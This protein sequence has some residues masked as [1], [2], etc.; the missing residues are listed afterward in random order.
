MPKRFG[1][2]EKRAIAI[3]ANGGNPANSNDTEVAR[4]WQWKINPSNANHKLPTTSVRANNRKLSNRNITPFN[5]EMVAGTFA[6][7][8]ISARTATAAQ[9]IA[10]QLGYQTLTA[11]QNS[12]P[13]KKFKPAQVYWRTGAA[14]TSA[15]RT[16]RITGRSYKSYYTNADEGYTASFGKVGTDSYTDRTRAITTALGTTINLI[17]FTAEKA[18]I[19]ATTG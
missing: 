13:L 17:T 7:V 2:L 1:D 10:T 19:A 8:Q 11:G 18:S 6:Q 4:Y 15:A 9:T 5:V 12:Y 3:L 16:S 14:T